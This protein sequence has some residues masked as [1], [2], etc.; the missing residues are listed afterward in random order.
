MRRVYNTRVAFVVTSLIIL[1]CFWVS[2]SVCRAGTGDQDLAFGTSEWCLPEGETKFPQEYR[3][4]LNQAYKSLPEWLRFPS[5]FQCI[6]FL[7]VDQSHR[8]GS[9]VRG[10]AILFTSRWPK[11]WDSLPRHRVLEEMRTTLSHELGHLLLRDLERERRTQYFRLSWQPNLS[12]ISSP[13]DGY[14]YTWVAKKGSCFV[15]RTAASPTAYSRTNPG[16]DWSVTVQ[17][18]VTDRRRL[19]ITCPEKFEA[20]RQ[21]ER[22]WQSAGKRGGT[23]EVNLDRGPVAS[24]LEADFPPQ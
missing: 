12:R 13:H 7:E 1:S 19:Q 18:F 15:G 11:I 21:I 16:E 4:L 5:A 9:Y 3:G 20:M 2:D 24:K 8:V 22:E 14:P 6:A 23:G 10:S 17:V